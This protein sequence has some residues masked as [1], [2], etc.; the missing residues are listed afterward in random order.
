MNFHIV[1]RNCVVIV[2]IVVAE[3]DRLRLYS[4]GFDLLSK[5]LVEC[6]NGLK[7]RYVGLVGG[8]GL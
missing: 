7:Y 6:R 1:S 3:F 8:G 4:R 5:M 2:G